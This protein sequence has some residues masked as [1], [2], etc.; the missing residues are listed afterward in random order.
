MAD[1]PAIVALAGGILRARLCFAWGKK[2]GVEKFDAIWPKTREEWSERRTN[3]HS[4]TDM[5]FVE[6]R[7]AYAAVLKDLME[8]SEAMK[9]AWST[10]PSRAPQSRHEAMLRARAREIEVEVE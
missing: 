3:P 9:T 8:P 7:A 2:I 5:A 6:A 10:C 4:E 1:H